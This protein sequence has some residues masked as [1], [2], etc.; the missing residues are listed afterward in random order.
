MGITKE[1]KGLMTGEWM[2]LGM[3]AANEEIINSWERKP[4]Q[5]EKLTQ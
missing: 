5:K 3:V 2:Q 1:L 4:E